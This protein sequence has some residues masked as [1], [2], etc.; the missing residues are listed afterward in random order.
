MKNI[1]K[2]RNHFVE[3]IEQNEFVSERHNK[4][5]TTLNYIE[6]FLILASLVTERISISAFAFLVGIFIGSLKNFKKYKSI[7]KEKKK[8]LDKIVILA[9]T[10]LNSIKVLISKAL[11]DS[12]ISQDEFV[13][14]N[15]AL[16]EYDDMKE[17]IKNLNTSTNYP[18]L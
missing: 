3:V 8:N 11:T 1:E 14:V 16:R 10:K 17:E 12:Y 18:K 2:T 7:I 5:C 13:L 4:I 15:T 6:H 9:K